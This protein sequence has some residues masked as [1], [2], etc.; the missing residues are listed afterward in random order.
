MVFLLALEVALGCLFARMK[1]PFFLAA[2]V[3]VAGCATRPSSPPEQDFQIVEAF[4][5]DGV[6]E[7]G[8]MRSCQDNKSKPRKK[9]LIQ[10]EAE[11]LR[12]RKDYSVSGPERMRRL[13]AIWK[14]QL[15]VMDK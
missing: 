12:V 6:P 7:N 10:L 11:E 1:I 15:A 13:R 3:M 5:G 8:A 2:T 9:N 4:R 14:E